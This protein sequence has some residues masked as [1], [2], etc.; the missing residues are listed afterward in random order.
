[1]GYVQDR[2]DVLN[3]LS[4]IRFKHTGDIH[5]Q[6]RVERPAACGPSA[7]GDDGE[8]MDELSLRSMCFLA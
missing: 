6:A 4:S 7:G 1:M 5:P 8:Q 3:T 2:R